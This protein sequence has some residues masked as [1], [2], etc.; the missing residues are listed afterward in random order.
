MAGVTKAR[1]SLDVPAP[2]CPHGMNRRQLLALASMPWASSACGVR[3][4]ESGVRTRGGLVEKMALAA[5]TTPHAALLHLA[6]ARGEFAREGLQVTLVPV[7]HGK[8]AI[9]LLAQGKVDLAAAAEVPF[10]IS[11]LQGQDFGLAATVASSS[12]EMALVARSDRAI[13][14]P[15][16]LA[17]RKVGVTFGTSGEYFLWAFLIRYRI[18]P[19]SVELVNLPP[20]RMAQAIAA[21]EVDAVATWEPVVGQA[22]AALQGHAMFFVEPRAYTVMHV[23]VG[24]LGFLQSRPDA[25]RK[26]LRALL[27][28][29]RYCREHPHQAMVL[30]AQRL[31]IDPAALQPAWENLRLQVDL[32]QS[33]LITLEDEA[34]WARARGHVP[35]GGQT[36]FLHHLHLDALHSVRP[37]RV[38]VVH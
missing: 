20:G 27:E 12:K 3:D 34:R 38:T 25:M 6:D 23:L 18:G 2:C 26:V 32:R 10:V 21:T 1:D 29:E 37:D 36:N 15:A 35:P 24:S 13:R 5:S 14:G 8:A 30:V 22:R 16:D 28:A 17:G 11:V 31:E 19:E 7:S 9:D 33:Q 4:A